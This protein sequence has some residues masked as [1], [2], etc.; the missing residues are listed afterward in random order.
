MLTLCQCLDNSK[1]FGVPCCKECIDQAIDDG[2]SCYQV[3]CLSES[4]PKLYLIQKGDISMIDKVVEIE[5][6]DKMYLHHIKNISTGHYEC[7]V[8]NEKKETHF[9]KLYV[10]K[11]GK[12]F[13]F[14]LVVAICCVVYYSSQWY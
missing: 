6:I 14:D 11:L 12:T 5:L 10:Q 13:L 9:A 1:I 4:E 7:E 2:T 3:G 8:V